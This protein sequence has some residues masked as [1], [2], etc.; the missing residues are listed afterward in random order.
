MYITLGQDNPIIAVLRLGRNNVPIED[1]VRYDANVAQVDWPF[2]EVACANIPPSQYPRATRLTL[3]EVTPVTI[4]P[5]GKPIEV[6]AL[7]AENVRLLAFGSVPA[8]VTMSMKVVREG[9]EIPA[10][11]SLA[12]SPGSTQFPG[13]PSSNALARGLLTGQVE[14]TLSNLVVDGVPV[15][16]GQSC[17]TSRPV[18]LNVWGAY[19]YTVIQ[20]GAMGAY[21][22]MRDL[23]DALMGGSTGPLRSP[24]YEEF[25]GK[26]LAAPT[27]VDIPPF[28]DCG[29]GGDDLSPMVTAMA[30][31][32]N[33]PV[34]INQAALMFTELD[35]D[36][37]LK[38]DAIK[39]PLPGPETP[40]MPPLPDGE[41]R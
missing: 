29:V 8:T 3:S 40:E 41:T 33:N 19:P 28:K 37:L 25:E 15:E 32:P 10:L 21:D 18:N 34:R 2:G 24:Y 30:S 35:P 6:G 14:I 5:Q 12:W 22:G 17:R 7:P 20:G 38:C 39:C 23:T 27:G 31:G 16:L 36:N 1:P 26:T 13:C 11:T 4:T 9:D